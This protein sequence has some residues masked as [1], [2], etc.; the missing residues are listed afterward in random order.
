MKNLLKKVLSIA[1]VTSLV[2]LSGCMAKSEPEKPAKDMIKEAMQNTQSAQSYAYLLNVDADIAGPADQSPQNMKFDG[3][4]G[5]VMHYGEAKTAPNFTL[6]IDGN[7]QLNADPSAALKGEVRL[8]DKTLYAMV[9]K[10]PVPETELPKQLSD[11]FLN[12]WWS[13]P[14]PDDVL[15]QIGLNPVS[16][17]EEEAQKVTA[18]YEESNFLNPEFEGNEKVGSVNS[19]KYKINFDKEKFSEFVVKV[20][21][22][23]GEPMSEGDQEDFK[24]AL[25][26]VTI[27]GSVYIADTD[28]PYFTKVETTVLVNAPEDEIKGTVKLTWTISD[29]NDADMVKVPEGAQP[30]SPLLLGALGLIGS[31]GAMTDQS[32][33]SVDGAGLGV[34]VDASTQLGGQK[35]Q[36]K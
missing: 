31:G 7:L 15:S 17:S 18:A 35:I 22:I 11:T 2:V 12:I 10:V 3:T 36:V 24:K 8:L 9:E 19:Y 1:M 5:G 28:A 30:F 32:T 13:Y 14:L 34:D 21:E 27:A 4:L 6:A 25:E 16:A 33:L 29:F 23:R 26:V 20:A